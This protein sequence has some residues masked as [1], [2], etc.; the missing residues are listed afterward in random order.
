M[1]FTIQ[2]LPKSQIEI[3][4]EIPA[5]EFKEHLEIA[6][7]N[8]GKD[9]SIEGFR[10]GKVPKEIIEKEVGA[11][12][13]LE[14]A[15]DLAIKKNY[16][17]AILENK[18]EAIGQPEIQ[19]LKIAKGSPFEFKAKASVI[20]EISLPDYKTIASIIKPK[21][22][23]VEEKEVD[24]TIKFLQKSRAKFLPKTEPCQKEDFV[25]ISFQSDQIEEGKEK[26]DSFVLGQGHFIPG[27]EENIEGL[28]A[29][30]EKIFSLRFPE[31]HIQKN[32]AG[33]E[34][35]FKVKMLSVAK[36]E[37]PEINDDWAKSFGNFEN[38]EG[39]KKNIE[40]GIRI[41][42][43][44]EEKQKKRA[45]I[46]EKISEKISIDN[47]DVLIDFEKGQMIEELKDNLQNQF[48]ISFNDY[49]AKIKKTNEEFEKSLLIEAEARVKNYLILREIAKKEKISVSEDE[50]EEKIK[51]FL[52]NYP[53]AEK[54]KK[55]LDLEKLKD[56][57]K[58]VIQ[59]EKTFQL[60][61]KL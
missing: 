15:A 55:E 27:F 47:P 51:D 1:K 11:A 29:G 58:G 35:N 20:P 61:E 52:K 8:I 56:Y 59:N 41:E 54:A 3:F 38:T 50:I 13:I 48:K 31:T 24:E 34:I 12:K 4:F 17:Q 40:E 18:I 26:K 49:L 23:L 32:L 43:T 33:K 42:K 2:K 10:K 60:L 39:L 53:G 21:E 6:T 16:V 57:Y 19:I 36:T 22:V 14:E 37:L 44:E 5:E 45:E 7:K 28:K 30:E 25:E 9:F 46:L